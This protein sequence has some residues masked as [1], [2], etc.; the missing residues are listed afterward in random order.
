MGDKQSLTAVEAWLLWAPYIP[1]SENPKATWKSF[2]FQTFCLLFK[3]YTM[4]S[5]VFMI[6]KKMVSPAFCQPV[7]TLFVDVMMAC[8]VEKTL[9]K[10]FVGFEIFKI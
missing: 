5:M 2:S 6:F 9:D 1:V 3:T 4:N 7:I 8:V 10:K